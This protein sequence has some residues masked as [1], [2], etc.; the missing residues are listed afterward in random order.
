MSFA[1]NAQFKFGSGI[2]QHKDSMGVNEV[3]DTL[4]N[5]EDTKV[6][7]YQPDE[8]MKN[9]FK[10]YLQ[11]HK[12][13]FNIALTFKDLLK[14]FKVIIFFDNFSIQLREFKACFIDIDIN[15]KGEDIEKLVAINAKFRMDDPP[16]K[17]RIYCFYCKRSLFIIL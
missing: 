12:I 14:I 7:L 13:Y 11:K 8:M 10:K 5:V 17:C 9:L 1:N 2:I 16:Y 4:T 3:G 6:L 15:V